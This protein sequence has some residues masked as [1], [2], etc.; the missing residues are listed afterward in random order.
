MNITSSAQSTSI[1]CNKGYSCQNVNIEI[2]KPT[3]KLTLECVKGLACQNINIDCPDPYQCQCK[4]NLEFDYCTGNVFG[5]WTPYGST[6]PT[7]TPSPTNYPS[8]IPTSSPTGSPSS[9]PTTSPTQA[10]TDAPTPNPT[11]NPSVSTSS[12]SSS[13]STST[14]KSPIVSAS[15]SASPTIANIQNGIGNESVNTNDNNSKSDMTIVIICV[16]IFWIVICISVPVYMKLWKGKDINPFKHGENSNHPT[17]LSL[18]QMASNS[19]GANRH[20]KDLS[21]SE[22]DKE[23][24]HAEAIECAQP[25]N[26][27]GLMPGWGFTSH[28]PH[29]SSE[30]LIRQLQL[31]HVTTGGDHS[32]DDDINEHM[33]AI[34]E[35]ASADPADGSGNI[36]IM[37]MNTKES[38][39]KQNN[40]E[41]DDNASS[42][43]SDDEEKCDY[44]KL[45][46]GARTRNRGG[47]NGKGSESNMS[48]YVRSFKATS[49]GPTR[50]KDENGILSIPEMDPCSPNTIFSAMALDLPNTPIDEKDEIL[51]DIPIDNM[52]GD[53][54]NTKIPSEEAIIGSLSNENMES[55]YGKGNKTRGQ[56]VE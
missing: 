17:P 1:T 15:T 16:V 38:I 10:P 29:A 48:L 13:S 23:H 24:D 42:E 54:M 9:G 8:E 34:Q 20:L 37:E 27:V 43:T 44:E 53:G 25:P 5:D 41:A 6:T 4:D 50:G 32:A 26:A 12:T 7:A 45:Y 46:E 19:S 52:D 28:R 31:Q 56:F 35:Q 49:E 51:I 22:A 11:Q 21:P 30:G 47:N 36:T 39:R 14:S 2:L 33:P 3:N 55:L 40:E 18:H